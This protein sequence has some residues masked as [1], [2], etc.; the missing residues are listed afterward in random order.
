LKKQS[1]KTAS[2]KPQLSK[3]LTNLQNGRDEMNLC[4]L[5]F[6]T[7]SERAGHRKLLHFEIKDFDRQL[8]QV[9][10][11]T[12]TV[13]GDPEYGLPTEKDEEIFFGA[14]QIHQRLQRLLKIASG[15]LLRW[16]PESK[17]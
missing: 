9:V 7:L 4:E 2:S 15:S 11:R 6:G 13:K 3:R 8:N 1:K 16:P 17:T 14:A 10:Q 5:P 12:L